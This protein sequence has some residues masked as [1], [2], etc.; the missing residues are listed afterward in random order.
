MSQ[1]KLAIPLGESGSLIY[2]DN[3]LES[4]LNKSEKK[5]D[6]L[7]KKKI[8]NIYFFE[9]SSFLTSKLKENFQNINFH[10][11]EK[12]IPF[13]DK[14][15]ISNY[16]K[17]ILV[18]F[19]KN[20]TA[21]ILFLGKI[22]LANDPSLDFKILT[23]Y[24]EI[25]F[26]NTSFHSELKEFS[27]KLDNSHY[28]IKKEDIKNL[29]LLKQD[30]IHKPEIFFETEYNLNALDTEPSDESMFATN[31]RI[32]FN[33]SSLKEITEE[34]FNVGSF[35]D[36][37]NAL[38]INLSSE[39]NFID[40]IE[41]TKSEIE[42]ETIPLEPS[43]E[44]DFNEIVNQ[45]IEREEE[46]HSFV[47][48][49]SSLKIDDFQKD[50]NEENFKDLSN[51]IE[52]D[53]DEKFEFNTGIEELS[54]ENEKILNIQKF[55]LSFPKSV[56]EKDIKIQK[57]KSLQPEFDPTHTFISKRIHDVILKEVLSD[58]EP[59]LQTISQSFKGIQ[60]ED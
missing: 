5:I 15:L 50:D 33:L 19:E 44:I 43:K 3:D 30:E 18:L 59:K 23:H 34:E 10:E 52:G 49:N 14:I 60:L 40:S 55:D 16:E 45:E 36:E 47:F 37:S 56:E 2:L 7:S 13:F 27:D 57:L 32:E 17:N 31:P 6:E 41:E 11:V 20:L 58:E 53:L 4:F 21:P 28:H 51:I 22:L 39:L 8:S 9:L 25:N 26:P 12:E 46:E 38:D 42:I 29:K 1:T 24:L 48:G 35:T 54:I